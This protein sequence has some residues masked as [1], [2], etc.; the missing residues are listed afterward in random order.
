MYK[1]F[2]SVEDQIAE[3]RNPTEKLA[4]KLKYSRDCQRIREETIRILR[5]MSKFIG[6]PLKHEMFY[7]LPTSVDDLD[8]GMN[9]M[10]R[11]NITHAKLC[12]LFEQLKVQLKTDENFA[13]R[14]KD[15]LRDIDEAPYKYLMGYGIFN[16]YL[17]L[18]V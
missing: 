7:K 3:I 16:E 12:E 13:R 5:E 6:H 10:A 14:I 1:C 15:M 2:R 4:E 17:T 8:S 9:N 11:E 18:Q